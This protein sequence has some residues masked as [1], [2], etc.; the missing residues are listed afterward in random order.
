MGANATD[1]ATMVDE[2]IQADYEISDELLEFY[3]QRAVAHFLQ[4]GVRMDLR[5][6]G[7]QFENYKEFQRRSSLEN[8]FFR[9][10]LERLAMG[11]VRT[12]I[13][14]SSFEGKF[15]VQPAILRTLIEEKV[16]ADFFAGVK[17]AVD[18][19]RGRHG[20]G[21]GV[22]GASWDEVKRQELSLIFEELGDEKPDA[23]VLMERGRRFAADWLRKH[24]EEEREQE[25]GS[26]DQRKRTPSKEI[27]SEIK[28]PHVKDAIAYL[29]SIVGELS[30]CVV[31]QL[32]TECLAVTKINFVF[33]KNPL[34]FLHFFREM[35]VHSFWRKVEEGEIE[36]SDQAKERLQ[37]VLILYRVRTG[38]RQILKY[39][40]GPG[41]D[42]VFMV[43]RQKVKRVFE[44]LKRGEVTEIDRGGLGNYSYVA[45]RRAAIDLQRDRVRE[46]KSRRR[47][48]YAERAR[49]EKEE[50]EIAGF[51][52]ARVEFNVLKASLQTLGAPGIMSKAQKEAGLD[53]RKPL[54]DS[55]KTAIEILERV[56]FG[57]EDN[58]KTREQMGFSSRDV[59]YQTLRRIRLIF[60]KIGASENLMTHLMQCAGKKEKAGV[61]RGTEQ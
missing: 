6:V 20:I 51:E 1:R 21:D 19:E 24:R 25:K 18:G 30:P 58:E 48:R 32:E 43:L 27:P 11:V 34:G 17:I 52:A 8:S 50:K 36:L 26:F 31:T 38:M 46:R 10:D 42:D 45:G 13:I 9:T 60:E 15:Y 35:V 55:Q 33:A 14:N 22:F 54:T 37:V 39:S 57:G 23:H 41:V 53:K 12:W 44:V 47:E 56:I 3:F 7:E 16:R 5:L 49:K 29:Q 28:E 2:L 59:Y 40:P 61:R 4:M